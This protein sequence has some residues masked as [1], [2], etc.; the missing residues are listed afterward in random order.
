MPR[1]SRAD[2]PAWPMSCSPL[3]R[4]SISTWLTDRATAAHNSRYLIGDIV[5]NELMYDPISGNDDDQYIELYNQG[6]N[7]VSLANWSS[8]PA[9][10]SSSPPARPWR[11]TV[12]WSWPGTRPTC[13]P[14]T[15]NLSWGNTVGGFGGKLSHKG[16]RVAL[17]MP[18]ALTVATGSGAVTNTIFVVEDEVTYGTG[19]RWGQWA[20]A[21][22][23]SLELINPAS[24]H[25]LAA[26]WADSDETTKSAWTNL[27]S[28]VS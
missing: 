5:I 15:L 20:H 12:T 8:S 13:L 10:L 6:T 27:D 2:M 3:G 1:P 23:S 21:G 16:E 14:S 17:A 4:N 7:T 28:P 19:G 18:Q 9:C 24:N 25:R 26:N 11:P 22:G